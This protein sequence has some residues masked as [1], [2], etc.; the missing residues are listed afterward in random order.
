MKRTSQKNHLP[1]HELA[2]AYFDKELNEALVSAEKR[3]VTDAMAE[4]ANVQEAMCALKKRA[5]PDRS[6]LFSTVG[7]LNNTLHELPT[8]S[9][10]VEAEEK[11][12]IAAPH[13]IK[14]YSNSVRMAE[15][16]IQAQRKSNL[17]SY[18]E[19]TIAQAMQCPE[20]HHLNKECYIKSSVTALSEHARKMCAKI[21][22]HLGAFAM[23]CLKIGGRVIL[24]ASA[25]RKIFYA[26]S[27]I[28]YSSLPFYSLCA[29]IPPFMFAF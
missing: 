2:V 26:I 5:S 4:L 12:L 1:E 23:R 19:A 18:I 14:E 28:Y 11:A 6:L 15:V 22:R 25:E 3:V 27:I 9:A 21:A 29:V 7:Y 13:Y 17:Q 8:A 20:A 10:W 24:A 16:T